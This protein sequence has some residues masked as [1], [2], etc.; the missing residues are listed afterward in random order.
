ML[1]EPTERPTMLCTRKFM[2]VPGVSQDP[3][4]PLQR[5]TAAAAAAQQQQKRALSNQGARYDLPSPAS[6]N[7]HS[8]MDADV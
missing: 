6:L 1:T 2:P 4:R 8:T 5:A 3:F 7:G